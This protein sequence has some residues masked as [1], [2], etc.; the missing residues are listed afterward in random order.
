MENNKLAVVLP[1]IGYHKDKP[2][3]Y[4]STKL[5]RSFGYEIIDISYDGLPKKKV[6]DN[7]FMER[8]AGTAYEQVKKQLEK[9]SFSDYDRI[10]FIGKSLGT[11]CAARYVKEFS[12][13]AK[14]IWY[15]PVERTFSYMSGK[16]SDI[17]SFI[18]NDDPWSD[19]PVVKATAK[20]LG[21]ELVSYPFCNHSLECG[22]V[23]RDISNIRDVMNRTTLF[24][25]R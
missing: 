21:I 10:V 19:I 4:Y 13:C 11:V 15:T 6:G 7:A 20:R 5:V 2:L 22:I 25:K 14:Q 3:L 8:S 12:L 17:I 24:L 1:G 23:D 18:G 9:I 16:S